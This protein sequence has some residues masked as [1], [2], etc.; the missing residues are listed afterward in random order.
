EMSKEQLVS[1]LLSTESLVEGTK[2]KTGKLTEDEWIR[3]IEAGDIL[4]KTQLYFD[5]N[6]AITV[7]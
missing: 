2:L 3:V 6:P 5:D 1:R 4:S 7:P